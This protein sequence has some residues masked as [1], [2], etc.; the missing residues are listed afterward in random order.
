MEKPKLLLYSLEGQLNYRTWTYDND[1]KAVE[2]VPGMLYIYHNG[3]SC[4]RLDFWYNPENEQEVE[5]SYI[6]ISRARFP[7]E[8][9]PDLYQS[10][11]LAR[12]WLEAREYNRKDSP[13]DA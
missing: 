4:V 12:E 10:I 11:E 1:W 8:K 7:W 5:G 3:E 9:I 2:R 13:E 6:D